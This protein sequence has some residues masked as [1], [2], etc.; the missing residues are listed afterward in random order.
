[1]APDPTPRSA[2]GAL[3]AWHWPLLVGLGACAIAMSFPHRLVTDGD[4]HLHI[5]VGRWI[6][7]HRAI[8]FHDPFSF[9]AAGKTWVPHE[10]GAEIVLAIA[11]EAL[12]WGGVI[13]ATGL[14]IFA[15]FAILTRALM[16]HFAPPRA[17]LGATLAFLLTEE[18]LLARPHVIALPLMVLWMWRIIA[19]RDEGRVPSPLLLPVMTLWCNLHGG[20]VVGL[21]FVA[22]LGSEAVIEAKGAERIA[23]AR[24]WGVFFGLALAS[25]LVSPNF[26]AGLLLPFELMRMSYSMAAIAEWQG[27]SFTGY[28]P[29]E[30]WIVVIALAGLSLGL[31]LKLTR[32][33]MVLLLLHMA[34]SHVRN[35]ELLGF[36]APLLVAAPL[37]AHL[38]ALG[39][40]TGIEAVARAPTRRAAAIAALVVALGFLAT[41]AL[42]DAARFRPNQEVAPVA[43]LEAVR[44]AGIT[45]PVLNLYGFGGF[46]V[47]SGVP[48]FIDGRADLYGDN[49]IRSF[50]DAVNGGNDDDLR[51][52]LERYAIQWTMFEPKTPAVRLL[53]RFPDWQRVYADKFA[54]VHRRNGPAPQRPLAPIEGPH[55]DNR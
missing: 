16:R 6:I 14:A 25:A 54:V 42:F 9:T 17:A 4:T 35:A 49:F 20:F 33:A 32:T 21:G 2:P 48:V 11:Y 3:N 22:L 28:Q 39:L 12:G 50:V 26:I 18:H 31:R 53:D 47:F 29:V 37:A 1:M 41:A 52:L 7:A 27:A 38:R 45:G 36:I 44:E 5:A 15:S 51:Q 34:L 23:A 43:A 30:I 24:R 46:L 10:W 40:A 13:A 55:A 8:P 19:A